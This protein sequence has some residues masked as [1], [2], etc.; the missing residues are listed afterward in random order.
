MNTA[1]LDDDDDNRDGFGETG[2]LAQSG[3]HPVQRL[4]R[5]D[6]IG[7]K[8]IVQGSLGVGGF[9]VVYEAEHCALGKPV[10]IKVMHLEADTSPALVERFRQEARISAFIHH[11]NVLDVYDTGTLADG[12]PYL[13]M[14][15]IHGETL[16]RRMARRGLT[17]PALVEVARQ[18]L[19]ALSVLYEA[20]IVHRDIKP[21]N[22]MLSSP[23]RGLTV[24]KVLDFGISKNVG[25]HDLHLTIGGSMIGTP[26][27][28]SPEQIRGE[29]VDH[30]S[31]LYALGV[32]LY[33]AIT[34]RVPFDAA[35]L[36]AL[37]LA[38]LNEDLTPIH[39]LRPDC[40][41]ELERIVLKAMARDR[42]ERYA[43]PAEMLADLERL[44]AATHMP[45]GEAAW[46]D[47]IWA[48][49]PFPRT[50]AEPISLAKTRHYHSVRDARVALPAP[51]RGGPSHVPPRLREALK[52]AVL[53]PRRVGLA[54]VGVFLLL[55]ASVPERATPSV[56]VASPPPDARSARTPGE[57]P[58]TSPSA[59]QTT[60]SP[61]V[62][63]L[64]QPVVTELAPRKTRARAPTDAPRPPRST[65]SPKPRR[66]ELTKPQLARGPA[67]K[68]KTHEQSLIRQ[69]FTAYLHDELERA[70]ALYKRAVVE[71]PAE[72]EAW[73]GL[74]LV[75][76]RLG[77]HEEARRALAR[78]L[79]LVPNARDVQAVAERK[80][81]AR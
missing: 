78:Y 41:A 33:E 9:A 52:T 40:P 22:I 4:K 54:L 43:S 68:R 63:P 60:L 35:T 32:V 45:R 77:R 31:D 53:K 28:M 57:S 79:K 48:A 56:H 71:T 81:A 74:G 17:I 64:P 15:L 2:G 39:T 3:V 61:V 30:R 62:E 67:F 5:G 14:E 24:V 7:D 70:H 58:Q 72:S 69:A 13:V 8:Y 73:R 75:A 44:A 20:G 80:P 38:A 1:I 59:N 34:G 51:V 50:Q 10:A 36:N 16:Y 23:G 42:D 76:A 12:S 66:R 49:R 65:A 37:V 21:E 29:D 26:H 6:P 19:T 27:Y 18:L 47:L 11:P 55:A 46:G 25:Q